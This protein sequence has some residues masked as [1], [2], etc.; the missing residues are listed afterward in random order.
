LGRLLRSGLYPPIFRV[1]TLLIF[2]LTLLYSFFGAVKGRGNLG[3]LITWSIWWPLL[4]LALLLTG[5]F[6]CA[7]CPISTTIGWLQRGK[8]SPGRMPGPLVRRYGLWFMVGSLVL[9][10]WA[11]G[12]WGTKSTSLLSASILSGLWLFALLVG[13]LYQRLTFCRHLCPIGAYTGIFSMAAPLELRARQELCQECKTLDCY[14]GNERAQGCP[15]F[16]FP[17]SM[18]SNRNC[19]L[20]ANCIKSCPYGA[21][22]VR[23]RAAPRELW[24]LRRP[25]LGESL[26]APVILAVVF[27]EALGLGGDGPRFTLFF[28]G[29]IAAV[30]AAYG[31]ASAVSSLAGVPL[32]AGLS[33]FGYAYIPLALGASLGYSLTRYLGIWGRA[34][35]LILEQLRSPLGAGSP[36]LEA[37]SSGGILGLA[38]LALGAFAS[39]YVVWRA[40]RQR[41][42]VALPHFL[43]LVGLVA[44][45]PWLFG[46][47]V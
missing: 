37:A 40:A 7:I 17:R 2:L 5:R 42:S 23:L 45:F 43:L 44:A 25:L 12:V 8:R 10:L 27:I 35:G 34:P 9:L 3:L 4:P 41:L 15:L 19:N 6:F 24:R 28:F 14:R 39:G 46:R 47:G 29:G 11:D 16:E 21:V 30:L 36:S 1:P 26:L 22:E 18:D 31:L 33:A 32:R 20:C 38:L 13:L